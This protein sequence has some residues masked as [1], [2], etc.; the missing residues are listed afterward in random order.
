MKAYE[1]T[2]HD[3][4]E[5]RLTLLRSFPLRICVTTE[6]TDYSQIDK[7]S[8]CL[9]KHKFHYAVMPHLG[10]WETAKLWNAAETFNLPLVIGQTAPTKNGSEPLQKSFLEISDETIVVSAVKQ[11][12]VGSGWVVRLF[13]PATSTINAKLRLNGG[14]VNSSKLSSPVERLQKE[15]AWKSG[16]SSR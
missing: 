10:D 15:M 3:Q 5:L 13:N 7:S 11:S 12:E 9:G 2:D 1:A 4:P 6:M 8:Q 16:P 14:K